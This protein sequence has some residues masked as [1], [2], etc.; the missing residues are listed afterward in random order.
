[1]RS[2]RLIIPVSSVISGYPCNPEG[3][4]YDKGRMDV[5]MAQLSVQSSTK[6]ATFEFILNN[7]VSKNMNMPYPTMFRVENMTYTCEDSELTFLEYKGASDPNLPSVVKGMVDFFKPLGDFPIPVR[8]NYDSET[9]QVM[10]TII[11]LT[12]DTDFFNSVPS[13]NLYEH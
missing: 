6:T 9:D 5:W 1:M 13:G 7:Q 11:A 8:A 2:L 3:V 10:A 4:Y 12:A